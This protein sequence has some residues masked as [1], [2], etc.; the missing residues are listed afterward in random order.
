MKYRHQTYSI[1]DHEITLRT[2]LDLDQFSDSEGKARAAGISK[3]AFPLF[4][5]VWTS[6]EILA[7]WLLTFDVAGLRILEVGCGMALVAHS[8]NAR[9]ADITAMD[10]HPR[11]QE[12][13]FDNVAL[14]GSAKI[15][16]VTSSW[17]E[18][19]AGLG[20]F[21]LIVGADILYEP[22]HIQTLPAF[23]DRHARQSAEVII[24]DPGRGDLTEFQKT[25]NEHGFDRSVIS[26]ALSDH[27]GRPYQG[28]IYH[29]QR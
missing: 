27:M 10:I 5:V 18:N 17:A 12:L 11:A 15:P 29:Y 19:P 21:D 6:S 20:E 26:P 16:F 23:I 7:E 9:G 4:G 22:K 14:M 2:L 28:V 13:F 25:M 1:G 3:E 24:A 8:L